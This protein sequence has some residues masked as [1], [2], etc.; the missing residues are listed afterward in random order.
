MEIPKPSGGKRL[1]GI[2]TVVDRWVQQMLLNVL[3]P[4]ST[5]M[6]DTVTGFDP[7]AVRM[8]R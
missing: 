7:D 2:P 8:M 5:L 6:S 1:L 3:Q 4:I